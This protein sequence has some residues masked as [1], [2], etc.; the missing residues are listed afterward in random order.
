MCTQK[1]PHNHTIELYDKYKETCEEY[2]KSKV[3]NTIIWLHII[4]LN[5]SLIKLEI[6][7]HIL[8]FYMVLECVISQKKY[9]DTLA[10]NL[11]PIGTKLDPI[12]TISGILII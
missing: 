11:D 6:I 5:H 8:L 2:I 1:S 9:L 10:Q 7:Y 3:S 12:W 4:F